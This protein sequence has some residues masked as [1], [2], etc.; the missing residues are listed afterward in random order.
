MCGRQFVNNIQY[1][2]SGLYFA[3]GKNRLDLGLRLPEDIQQDRNIAANIVYSSDIDQAV[4]V[5]VR[6]SNPL[7]LHRLI[8]YIKTGIGANI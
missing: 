2:G 7:F 8:R 3:N 5:K 4:V 6:L 1:P